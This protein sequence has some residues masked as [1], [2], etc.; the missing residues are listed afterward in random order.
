MR[1]LKILAEIV[2]LAV[3]GFALIVVVLAWRLSSGPLEIDFLT[4]YVEQALADRDATVEIGALS[5][6]WEGF[7]R[8]AALAARDV[9][10]RQKDGTLIAFTPEATADVSMPKLLRGVVAPLRIDLIRPHLRVTR[11]ETGEFSFGLGGSEAGEG[12]ASTPAQGAPTRD[13]VKDLLAALD[14]Q[15][16]SEGSPIASLTRLTLVDGSVRIDDRMLGRSWIAPRASA[17]LRR[18]TSGVEGLASLSVVSGDRTAQFD[19][20]IRY[21]RASRSGQ[22]TIT[23]ANVVPAALTRISPVL[24]PLEAI[25]SPVSGRLEA[26]FDSH[27]QPTT[28]R[29]SLTS[30]ETRLKLPL[31]WSQSFDAARTSLSGSV[32]LPK[33][34][35]TLDD[36]S[37]DLGGPRIS[38]SGQV[39]AVGD[40][41]EAITAGAVTNLPV[42]L[43]DSLWPPGVPSGLRDWITANLRDGVLDRTEFS[44]H[45]RAP[46][47]NPEAVTLVAADGTLQARDMTVTYFKGLPPITGL[48]AAASFNQSTMRI[49]T[50]GGRLQ[51]IALQP[52][53]ITITGLDLHDQVIDIDARVEGPVKT[54]M[55]V[56]DQPRLG[57][58]KKVGLVPDRMS[59]RAAARLH[60]G[61]S[62]LADLPFEAIRMGVE[63]TLSDVGIAAAKPGYDLAGADAKLT[64]DKAGMT[65]AGKGQI[66]TVPVAFSWQEA[67]DDSA[68]QTR[69][70]AQTTLTAA[71]RA[72]LRLPEFE[73]VDGTVGIDVD[74]AKRSGGAATLDAKLDLTDARIAID[75]IGWVKPTGDKANGTVSLALAG[76]RVAK[77][78]QFSVSGGDISAS[79]SA[80]FARDGSLAQLSIASFRQGPNDVKGQVEVLGPDSYRLALTGSRLDVS[81]ILEQRR[82]AQG[83]AADSSSTTS[84]APGPRIDA[85][86]DVGELSFGERRS[87]RAVH[88]RA[89]GRTTNLQDVT[90]AAQLPGGAPMDL[91]LTP[92]QGQPDHQI[93]TVRSE[94]AGETLQVFDIADNITGGSLLAT[95]TR[96][97]VT[98]AIEGQFDARNFVLHDAP[99]MARLL[100]ATS[101][102]GLQDL[103][104]TS[105]LTFNRLDADFTYAAAQRRVT[106]K[107]GRGAGGDLGLAF[108]GLIDLRAET[109]DLAGTIVPIYHINSVISSIPLIGDILT[110]GEG[111]GLFAFT[112]T[113]RGS[114][115]DPSVSVNPLSVLA[116][117]FLRRLFFEETPSASDGA[118]RPPSPQPPPR[119]PRDRANSR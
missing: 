85:T 58:A 110:G 62:L 47:S 59:G 105:G 16:G 68:V 101:P 23:F 96:N 25:E 91:R 8:P 73:P 71:A 106:L 5:L 65:L 48:N 20:E 35:L 116:P 52:S 102:S 72:A 92:Q 61:F 28:G 51:D 99:G 114:F 37:I 97:G 12:G 94:D 24:A 56:L 74:Y 98:G 104:G 90:L 60:F 109:I 42:D 10:V 87:L 1:A 32:D 40:T 27:F 86:F 100:A 88:G 14:A 2:G 29:F 83:K 112:Y 43:L 39:D 26:D 119:P 79:G 53:D 64:L 13:V 18:S 93:L 7:D 66:N 41:L 44:L 70:S 11:T 6:R 111:G 115:A 89:I 95:G 15:L 78:S 103:F 21:Q 81:G 50:A 36:F 34:R 75:P 77:V 4:P 63:G 108:D 69:V 38:L 107:Q 84:P 76:E 30:I 117:G 45:A 67:F 33:R 55:S 118:P 113:I 54:I 31:L 17:D 19:G 9:R 82:A 22:A 57:Y 80:D 49:V 46:L 3:A